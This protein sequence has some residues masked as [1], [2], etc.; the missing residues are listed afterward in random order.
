MNDD[1]NISSV[2][3]D[4]FSNVVSSLNIPPH[5]D[6]SVNPDQ[7]EDPVVKANEKYKNH[8]SIKAIKER[9]I[10]KVFKFQ[11]ISRSDIKKEILSLDSSKASQESEIPTKIIK[12]NVDIFTE[13][14]F[15]EFEKSLFEKFEYTSLFE[16]AD[17]TPVYKKSSRFEKSN[18]RPVSIL[19]VLSKV[20]EKCLY[21]QIS[22]YFDDIFSKYQCGFRK[23]FGAQH[24]LIAM[25]EKW[26][27]SMDKGKFFGAILTD[28]SKA[29][30]CLP[31]DLPAAKLSAY[32]FDNNSTKFLFDY[33]TNRKQKTKIGQVYS[34]W[35]KLTS[36]VPQGSILGP[37]I[38]NIDLIDI[39]YISSNYDIANYADDNTPYVTCETM[40]SLIESLEK[41]AE[42]IFKWFKNN[43]MQ[44]NGDKCHVLISTN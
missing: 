2:L 23:G 42:E 35:D 14:L 21:K 36:G 28:L 18:Y 43:E 16:F 7:F 1:E 30:D 25:I 12:Q 39:F 37:L 31:H 38:F 41:I 11:S 26:R 17:I 24:S 32:G 15:H 8:P 33:L 27:D 22:S 44:A 29:F 20:F 3:N 13:H 6:P 10:N 34:S 9:S 5:K 40:A 4:F 19:P